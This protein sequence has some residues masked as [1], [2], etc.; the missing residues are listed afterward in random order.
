MSSYLEDHRVG[1]IDVGMGVEEVDGQL[2]GLLRVTTSTGKNQTRTTV[3][4]RHNDHEGKARNIEAR[5]EDVLLLERQA[6]PPRHCT[7]N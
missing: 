6:P 3:S 5:A 1:Y 2:T 4:A 7:R